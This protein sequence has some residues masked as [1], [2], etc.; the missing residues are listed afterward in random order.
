M[1]LLNMIEIITGF[2]KRL[3][4]SNVDWR[5]T[6]LDESFH[7]MGSQVNRSENWDKY[8]H[9][10][11]QLIMI[12][13]IDNEYCFLGQHWNKSFI[14]RHIVG[15]H[16][17]VTRQ[18]T[19]RQHLNSLA[20]V[21]EFS[22]Q[23]VKHSALVTEEI[24]MQKPMM[25]QVTCSHYHQHVDIIWYVTTS[26]SPWSFWASYTR[27]SCGQRW[28]MTRHPCSPCWSVDFTPTASGDSEWAK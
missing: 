12:M 14:S 16:G 11:T 25:S 26:P 4:N 8:K 15:C 20:E 5:K 6:S 21:F 10:I 27:T 18:L 19:T 28:S 3:W 7:D 24:E 9:L 2:M 1:N 13:I 22:S 17:L 23:K